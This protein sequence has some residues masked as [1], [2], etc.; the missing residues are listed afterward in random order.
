M[1]AQGVTVAID[2]AHLAPSQF[3]AVVRRLE[4]AGLKVESR[5]QITGIVSGSIEPD[6]LPALARVPGVAAV[7]RSRE[8]RIPPPDSE[9]Q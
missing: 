4:Q 3:D 5:G 6:K 8:I 1:A 2:D 9:I 7:E